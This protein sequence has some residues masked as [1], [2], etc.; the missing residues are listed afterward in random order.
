MIVELAFQ[1]SELAAYVAALDVVARG[2]APNGDDAA[3][4][5]RLLDT[6]RSVKPSVSC[7]EC[8]RPSIC[9]IILSGTQPC[10]H[11]NSRRR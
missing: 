8:D 5:A 1:S 4:L 10:L 7:A 9:K 3:A 6:L 11:P 2:Y